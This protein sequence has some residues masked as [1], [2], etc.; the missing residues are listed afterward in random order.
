VIG[1]HFVPQ[2]A[3]LLLMTPRSIEH[4]VESLSLALNEAKRKKRRKKR[5]SKR[6]PSGMFYYMNYDVSGSSDSGDGGGGDGGGA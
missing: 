2:P 4:I 6:V 3:Y 5:K 1:D